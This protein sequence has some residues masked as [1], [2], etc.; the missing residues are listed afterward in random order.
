MR[1]RQILFVANLELILEHLCA[2]FIQHVLDT[3]ELVDQVGLFAFG[4]LL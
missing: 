2:P 3:I 1:N 4:Q